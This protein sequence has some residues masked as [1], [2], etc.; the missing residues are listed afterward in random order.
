MSSP[1]VVACCAG[2]KPPSAFNAPVNSWLLCHLLPLHLPLHCPPSTFVSPAIV[3]SL[4]L[5]LPA[6]VPMLPAACAFASHLATSC[7]L[8]SPG[9]SLYCLL[10]LVAASI[11]LHFHLCSP[12]PTS[13]IPPPC[14]VI[15]VS[16]CRCPPLWSQT[17]ARLQCSCQCWLS[18]RHTH[19]W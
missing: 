7:W 6:T 10:W 4:T 14:H 19:G 17:D 18:F 8:L 3:R 2:H 5:L 12:R 16:L 9:A 15:V 1:F 11:C 13:A